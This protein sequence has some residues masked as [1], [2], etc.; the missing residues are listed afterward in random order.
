VLA[1]RHAFYRELASDLACQV[2]RGQA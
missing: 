2:G 1:Q